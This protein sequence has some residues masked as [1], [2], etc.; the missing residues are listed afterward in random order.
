MGGM[1]RW[2]GGGGRGKFFFLQQQAL[3]LMQTGAKEDIQTARELFRTQLSMFEHCIPMYNIACCEALLGNTKESF[4]FLQKRQLLQD[5][6]MWTTWR[7][8]KT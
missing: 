2:C 7:K 8:M 6:V 3:R 5:T 1:K 4:E